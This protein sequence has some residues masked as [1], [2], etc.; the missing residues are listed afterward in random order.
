MKYEALIYTGIFLGF[1][2]FCIFGGLLLGLY[3]FQRDFCIDL[4][5]FGAIFRVII[6]AYG[7]IPVVME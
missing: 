1:Y 5:P 2:Y 4:I 6:Q 7:R 3:I